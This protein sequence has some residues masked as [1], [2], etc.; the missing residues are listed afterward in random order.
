LSSKSHYVYRNEEY[1]RLFKEKNAFLKRLIKEIII[2]AYPIILI[3]IDPI[4]EKLGLNLLLFQ[5][6][7]FYLLSFIVFPLV[8]LAIHILRFK[9]VKFIEIE[10]VAEAKDTRIRTIEIVFIFIYCILD[11]TYSISEIAV[12][13]INM[14]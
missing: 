14:S 9:R 10:D 7:S 12:R 4:I 8:L 2:L 13:T 1:N 5:K 3:Y 6:L 11:I